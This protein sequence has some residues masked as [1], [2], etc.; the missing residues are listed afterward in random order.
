MRQQR[1]EA[2]FLVSPANIAYVCGFSAV[3]FERLIALVLPS[4]QAPRLIV[5]LLEVDAALEQ[6][7]DLVEL[8]PW[9]DEDGPAHAVSRALIG[10]KGA[11]GVEK[12]HLSISRGELVTDSCP[13]ARLTDCDPLLSGLRAT[14]DAKE[15][16]FVRCAASIADSVM[17]ALQDEVRS[18][19]SEKE[20]SEVCAA[21]LREAGSGPR[22]LPPTVLTGKKSG[23]P[24]G[25]ADGTRLQEGDLLIIDF[26]ANVGG[27]WSDI[28]RTCFVDVEPDSRQS[29]L[30]SVIDEA[31]RAAIARA[32][33]GALCAEVDEAARSVIE[34]AGLGECFSHRTG[35]G[36]GLEIHEAPFF[37]ATNRDPVRPG[38]VATIEPGVYIE[39]YGGVRIEDDIL[40]GEVGPEVLTTSPVSSG[41]Q[42][43]S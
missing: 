9:R 43:R 6:T 29:E 31:R 12:S 42:T 17:V 7:A 15:I 26:G 40:I 32:V 8:V 41:S 22:S 30:I 34:S 10:L 11:V 24:H 39:G 19:R 37:H 28:T 25:R 21:L 3:P 4:D 33:P 36:L 5:P 38:M 23:L 13:T 16:E 14:K 27:Y 35:H 2:I 20:L 18:G 1:M